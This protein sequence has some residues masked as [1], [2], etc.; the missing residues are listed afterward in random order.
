[1]ERG[2]PDAEIAYDE[3]AP[4]LTKQQLAEFEPA[5]FVFSRRRK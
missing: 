1:M 4:R 2:M 3:D 5:K